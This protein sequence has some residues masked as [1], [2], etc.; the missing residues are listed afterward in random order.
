MN[1][2]TMRSSAF[3]D[4]SRHRAYRWDNPAA[5]ATA[6]KLMSGLELMEAMRAGR[7]PQPPAQRTLEIVPQSVG[8]GAVV[9]AL[10]PQELH[11]DALGWVHGGVIVAL[12]DTAMGCAVHTHLPAGT[13]YVSLQLS[14]EFL[15]PIAHDTAV[16][17]CTGSALPPGADTAEAVAR[18][19]DSA[20]R[21]MAT[22]K[23]TFR[24][25]ARV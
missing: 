3:S 25:R 23:S 5:V 16:V 6:A 24:L 9:F 10:E 13:G 1:I 21:L 8:T 17:V 20:G 12:L 14:T 18:V 15:R 4:S 2:P 22:A 7:L 19:E 11:C